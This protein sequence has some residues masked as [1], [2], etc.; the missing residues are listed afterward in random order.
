MGQKKKTDGR[1]R[2]RKPTSISISKIDESYNT[3]KAPDTLTSKEDFGEYRTEHDNH[4]N[5][6][7]LQDIPS[8]NSSI[9]ASSKVRQLI[10]NLCILFIQ[11]NAT[12]PTTSNKADTGAKNENNSTIIASLETYDGVN[13]KPFKATGLLNKSQL[14]LASYIKANKDVTLQGTKRFTDKSGEYYLKNI[15]LQNSKQFPNS[16]KK[17]SLN[18]PQNLENCLN[19][20]GKIKKRANKIV[21]LLPENSLTP[22]PKKEGINKL[23]MANGYGKKELNDAQRTAVFIRRLEYA[24]SMKKQMDVGKNLKNNTKKIGLIQ[25]WWKTMFKIIK[26]QK[27][28]RGFLFRKKLMNNLEHQEKLLQFI[29]EFDNI[30]NYHLYR[31]FMENLKKKGDYEKAKL[32]EKC[33]DF[34]EKLDNLERLHNLKNFKNCFNKWKND[35]KQKK[36]EDLDK[37]ATQL[38]DILRKRVN[39]NNLATLKKIKDK[40]QSDEDKLNDK[41]K[42]FREKHAK[43]N[44][45]NDLIKA[46]RLNKLLSKVKDSIDDNHKKDVLDKLKKKKDIGDA[47]EKLNKLLNDKMKKDALKDL[48][49]MDFVDKLDDVINKH[50]DKI[51]EEA[52]KE[53]MDKL[54]DIR[55]KKKAEEDKNKFAISSGVNDFELISDKKSKNPRKRRSVVMTSHN[56]INIAAKP[57][58]K[59]IFETSGQNK[60]SLIAPEK[61][62]FGKPIDKNKKIDN[63]LIDDQ[64]NDLKNRNDLRKYM[65]KWKEIRNKKDIVDKLKDK[66]NDLL[67]KQKEKEDKFKQTLDKLKKMK[68]KQDLKEYF[69]RW[70]NAAE[71]MKK[72]DLDNLAKKLNDILTKAKKESDDK[73]KK[74]SLDRLKK[75]NDIQ[76]G[77]EKLDDLFFRKPK[78]DALDTLKKNS[79]MSEGFRILDKLFK[80]NDDKNKKDFLD[81]LKKNADCQKVLE[82]LNKLLEKKLKKKFMDN[83]KKNNDRKKGMEILNKVINDNL[84][85]EFMDEIKKRNNLNKGVEDLEKLINNKLKKDVLNDL[86]NRNRIAVSGDKLEKLIRDKLKRKLMDR[87]DRIKKMKNATDKLNDLM[88]NKLK[89]DAFDN[90]KNNNN[91][92]KG[93]DILDKLIKDHNDKLKKD[94]FDQLKKFD[95][96]AKAADILE[97]LINKKL[98]DDTFKK[99]KTMQFVDILEKFRKNKD[100]KNNEQKC[101]KLMN[102]LKKLS[103]DKKEEEDKN[104]KEKLKDALDRWKD[105]AYRRKIKDDLV[106]KARKKKAFDH[107]KNI[108]EL[109]DILDKLKDK[110]EKELL[111]KYLKKWHDKCEQREIFDKLKDYLK[112]KK[113]FNDWKTN[114]ERISIFRNIKKKKLLLKMLKEKEKKEKDALKKYLDK[115]NEIAKEKPK[116]E[117]KSKRI[118]HRCN[119]KR[120]RTKSKKKNDRKLLKQAFDLWRE[121]SSFEP[122][123]NVLEKIK[124]N[125]LLKHNFENLNDEEKNDLLQKYKNKMLQVMLN[126]YKRQR[127]LVLKRYLDKWRRIKDEKIESEIDEPKYKK[128]PRIEDVREFTDSDV[129]SFNPTYY[130]T[131]QNTH[132]NQRNIP[133]KKRYAKKPYEQLEEFYEETPIKNEDEEYNIKE[134]KKDEFSDTSSNNESMLGNGEYLIQNKKT[135]RQPRNYTS[136]SFFIDKNNAKNIT[137]NNY[138]VNTHNT[139]QLP[140]TMKGDFV[141][142]IEQNPKILQQKN[143]RIQVTNA[144]CDLNQIINNENTED[145]LNSEEVN[146][147]M[148]KLNNNFIIDKNRVLSKVIKNC[149]KDLYASQRPF[150]SKKDQWYSVSIPL[151]DNEAKWEFLGN[152]KGERDKNNLNKFELIQKEADPIKEENEDVENK[153]Y[154]RK[155]LRSDKK[156]DKKNQSK[157]DSA[158]KL[159]EMNYSQF[160]RS[161]IKTPNIVEEEE[162]NLIGNRIKRPGQNQRQNTQRSFLNTSRYNRNYGRNGFDRSRGKINF[163]PKYRSIDYENGYEFEDSDD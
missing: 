155:T 59:L 118:S 154:S 100:D 83:L 140:M 61:F 149:D 34:N 131:K 102:T 10:I 141:S 143:P 84:K 107:W 122:T 79:G 85:K 135:I 48:K 18:N 22:I 7:N 129:S 68:D 148:D 136:Q 121:N 56:D 132:S 134:I 160:Y 2:S 74:D 101:R 58:P 119:S 82:D 33:E 95:D 139:N 108:K 54:K 110:K 5:K 77:L 39:K 162:K 138:Q 69:D 133:Y 41:A 116:N 159:R 130:N 113:A 17:N 64:L 156:S 86:K 37:L 29:T 142:L 145:E 36:K 123:R 90:L 106:D 137:S 98:K 94:A 32:M 30:H 9:Y 65:D 8:E 120:L 144:T 14:K 27:N 97:K 57:T 11:N 157:Q 53:L 31:Q 23:G 115:W 80:K 52:K 89:K 103:K 161:P 55:D 127:N 6:G 45:L 152:I 49:T 35:T 128:K 81:R 51:N 153:T 92:R 150:R 146:Y 13:K 147:E 44:F 46:H 78:K 12:N 126:I 67:K 71:Q 21:T 16:K 40:T 99:L 25:E 125:R 91:I 50:N 1:A 15:Q 43:K 26:L 114:S 19:N 42:E 73:N 63:K 163:D 87:L 66:L 47:A 60:F 70:K 93:V 28:M 72:D 76:K 151:N 75:Y 124:K 62:K 38:N 20:I 158:Y 24:T 111:D 4:E 104:N 105:I 3:D 117:T 109:R 96:I 88:N 112:K